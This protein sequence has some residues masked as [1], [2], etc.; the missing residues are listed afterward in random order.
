MIIEKAIL[1]PLKRWSKS[2][3]ITKTVVT[4]SISS[5]RDHKRAQSFGRGAAKLLGL[6]KG[7]KGFEIPLQLHS[8]NSHTGKKK[9]KTKTGQLIWQADQG[10]YGC[11]MLYNRELKNHDKVH[12]DDDD[13]CWLGKDWKEN[14]FFGGKKETWDCD[15]D[16][17]EGVFL[18]ANP[19]TDFWS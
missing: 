2:R 13:V 17:T 14:V 15:D 1:K 18:S 5:Q 3:R 12:D 11:C 8:Q 10:Y 9:S 7:R 19:K 6:G 4:I 16:D